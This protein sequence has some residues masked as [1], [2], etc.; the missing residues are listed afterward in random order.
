MCDELER[1]LD[2]EL[3]QIENLNGPRPLLDH[4]VGG[5]RDVADRPGQVSVSLFLDNS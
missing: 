1:K 2:V 4:A 5:V 3:A